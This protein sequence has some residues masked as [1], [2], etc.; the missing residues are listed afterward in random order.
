MKIT[1]RKSRKRK[2]LLT[3]DTHKNTICIS[4]FK[5][6]HFLQTSN[7]CLLISS[8]LP[9]VSSMARLCLK[10]CPWK[11]EKQLG[12][13]R[14]KQCK[15]F[16]KNTHFLKCLSPETNHASGHIPTSLIYSSSPVSSILWYDWLLSNY[17]SAALLL[18]VSSLR[19]EAESLERFQDSQLAYTVVKDA[20]V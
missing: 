5:Q 2:R 9:C 14:N 6:L 1:T 17:S 7:H 12:N 20:Y 16:L 13:L 3:G 18:T 10:Y 11:E 4:I 15:F 19:H 8:Y